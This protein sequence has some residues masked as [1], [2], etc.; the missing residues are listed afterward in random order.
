MPCSASASCSIDS[1][2]TL[3]EWMKDWESATQ[4]QGG[5]FIRVSDSDLGDLDLNG[6]SAMEANSFTSLT[7]EKIDD[8]SL[9][10][11]FNL[12]LNIYYKLLF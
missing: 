2:G 10:K 4:S 5:V 1:N 12:Y 11:N 7:D 3:K 9:K 6:D 8:K